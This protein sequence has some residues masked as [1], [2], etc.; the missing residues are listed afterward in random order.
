MGSFSIDYF[1]HAANILLLAAY[2][3]RDILWLRLFAVA[4]SL[5][6]IPYFLLQPQPLWAPFGWSILFTSINLFQ[7][8]RLFLERRSV[9]LTPEEE[10]VRRLVFRDL[11]PRKV[12]QII[13]IGSWRTPEPGERL[14]EP[15]KAVESISLIVR[16]KVRVTKEGRTLGELGVGEMVGSALLLSGA[17]ADVEAV[18]VESARTLRWEAGTLERFLNAHP[19]SR[20]AFQRHLSRDLAGKLQRLSK[21]LSD[22]PSPLP[23]S[24]AGR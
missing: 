7:S 14:I 11:P 12:L 9:S 6:A 4:S 24:A 16:G 10:E 3:I 15:G 20:D 1:I 2:S 13:S 19:D 17:V 8:W 18:T 5:A 21:D 23:P 22:I